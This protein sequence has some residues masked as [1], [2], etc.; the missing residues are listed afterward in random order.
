MKT[1]TLL[2]ILFALLVGLLGGYL[3]FGRPGAE[4]AQDHAVTADEGAGQT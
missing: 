3:L 4:E 2:Y 1:Q